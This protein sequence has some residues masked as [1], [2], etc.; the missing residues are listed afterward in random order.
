MVG[1]RA[2]GAGA[3]LVALGDVIVM[4][5]DAWLIFPGP[6]RPI[7]GM[8]RLVPTRLERQLTPTGDG[9]SAQRLSALGVVDHMVD[10]EPLDEV[11]AEVVHSLLD[12][13]TAMSQWAAPDAGTSRAGAGE[14]RRGA[15]GRPAGSWAVLTWPQPCGELGYGFST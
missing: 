15:R 2:I 5:E 7:P 14:S 12:L 4:S 3:L 1:G 8:S 13:P 9:I 10:P 6:V 11:A